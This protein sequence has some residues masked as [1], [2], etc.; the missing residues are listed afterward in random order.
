M[1]QKTYEVVLKMVF[2]IKRNFISEFFNLRERYTYFFCKNYYEEL[3]F[4]PKSIY[5]NMVNSVPCSWFLFICGGF[6]RYSNLVNVILNMR[7]YSCIPGIIIDI[8]KKSWNRKKQGVIFFR[9]V[10]KILSYVYKL[11]KQFRH[12]F[13]HLNFNAKKNRPFKWVRIFPNFHNRE[14]EQKQTFKVTKK[15]KPIFR[16]SKIK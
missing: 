7:R 1:I 11:E 9:Y 10:C 3:F 16:N 13:E 2:L 5:V 6:G 14:A 15:E 12:F 8:F 4:I